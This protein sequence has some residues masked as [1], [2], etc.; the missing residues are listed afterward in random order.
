MS[1]MHQIKVAPKMNREN[2]ATHRNGLA[3]WT[4]IMYVFIEMKTFAFCGISL[5]YSIVFV[6]AFEMYVNGRIGLLAE[7]VSKFANALGTLLQN[8]FIRY[9]IDNRIR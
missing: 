1:N 7:L 2:S 3:S 4:A 5:Q 8:L 6:H 9:I